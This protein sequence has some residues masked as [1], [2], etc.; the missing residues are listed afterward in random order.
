MLYFSDNEPVKAMR[1]RVT[2]VRAG[3]FRA[4]TSGCSEGQPIGL[5]TRPP[6]DVAFLKGVAEAS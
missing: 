6:A 5:N 3:P 1:T 4:L 2:E